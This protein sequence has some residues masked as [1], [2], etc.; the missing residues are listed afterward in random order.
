MAGL[1]ANRRDQHERR[2]FCKSR[3]RPPLVSDLGLRV[4]SDGSGKF[5]GLTSAQGRYSFCPD[6]RR[7]GGRGLSGSASAAL[8]DRH[9]AHGSRRSGRYAS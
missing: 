2:L 9:G 4:L 5:A 8:A 3:R 7:F 6:G 1:A